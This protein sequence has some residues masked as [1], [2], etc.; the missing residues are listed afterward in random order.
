MKISWNW[1]NDYIQA[2]GLTLNKAIEILTSTGL[3]VEGVSEYESLK[4]GLKNFYIGQVIACSKHPNADKL[5]L[6]EVDLGEEIGIKKIVCG[7][8]NVAQ[9]QK[10]VVALEGAVVYLPDGKSFEIKNSKIRGEESQG[11]ICAEDELGIGTSHDGILVLD[12]KTTIGQSAATY[13]KIFKDYVIEIG[14]TPNRTDAMSHKGVA[15]DIVAALNAR[16]ESAIFI[17]KGNY[18]KPILNEKTSKFSVKIETEK[19]SKF[20]GIVIEN[21]YNSPSPDWMQHRL[22]AIGETTKN[23]I[24][25][26]TNYILHDLG[27]PLHAYDLAK[28]QGNSIAAVEAR[29]STKLIA[30]NGKEIQVEPSDIIIENQ[31][32]IVGVAGVIGSQSSAVDGQT[33]GIFLEAAYFNPTSIRTTAQRLQLRTEAAMKFEKGVD[34]NGLDAALCKAANILKAICPN[35]MLG[36]IVME[37]KENISSWTTHLSRKKLDIY[38]N[39]SLQKEQVEAI[40]Q[41]LDIQV[42]SYQDEIWQLNIPTYRVD[43]K[44]EEDVIEEILRIYGYNNLPYPRFLKSNLSF[45]DGLTVTK[46]EE[47]V[48]NFLSSN[49]LQEIYTNSISQSKYY[50]QSEPIKLLNSMTSEL[51]CMRSTMLPSILEVVAYNLNRDQKDIAFFEIGNVYRYEKEKYKQHKKLSILIAGNSEIPNWKNTKGQP[52]DYFALKSVVENFLK[53]YNLN[54]KF[55][56]GSDGQFVYCLNT[57]INGK[58]IAILGEAKVDKKLFDIKSKIFYAEFDID[59]IYSLA[60]KQKIKYEEVSKFPT[61]KRDL[62]MVLRE[63]IR[64]SQIEVICQKAIGKYLLDVNLFDIFKHPS[65]GENKKSYAIRLSLNHPEKTMTDKEID[66][67]MQ[68]LIHQLKGELG[69]EIRMD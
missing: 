14:L 32:N 55:S 42:I 38:A 58:T 27:Q 10:V 23:S 67:M 4:G 36:N 65:L 26:T 2:D 12:E 46:F 11:M 1:L 31:G 5:S 8:P 57:E 19:T 50:T 49:G 43:V 15:R 22:Q 53:K 37:V 34:I 35:A 56:E 25:D 69:A 62:A 47:D 21:L 20:G 18:D 64:F 7:A 66:S 16:G 63:E 40:F 30:L 17:A 9:G 6:T 61:V 33:Q 3:E 45:T 59:Y 68:K 28:L 24:V 52:N 51:D 48:V 13:F 44:R 39:M 29:A 41:S 54:Y 60:A